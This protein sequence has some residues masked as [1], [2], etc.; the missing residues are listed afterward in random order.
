MFRTKE[1]RQPSWAQSQENS[2]ADS[3]ESEHESTH[4]SPLTQEVLRKMLKETSAD[5]KAYT[6]A[7]LEKQIAGLKGDIEA[8]ASPA[9]TPNARSKKC[10]HRRRTMAGTWG[11]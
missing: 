4:A 6:T 2:G 3:E 9:V 7:A 1:D 11:Y 5:I 10:K 8:L